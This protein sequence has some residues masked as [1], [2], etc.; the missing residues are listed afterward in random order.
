[1]ADTNQKNLSY[2]SI[3]FVIRGNVFTEEM[4]EQGF[5]SSSSNLLTDGY[6]I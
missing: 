2:L 1:M 4:G 5:S 3:E 6:P